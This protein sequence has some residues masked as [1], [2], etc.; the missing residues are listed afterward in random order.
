MRIDK[1]L[2]ECG[3]ASRTESAK[4]A[5]A[6]QIIVN[7]QVVKKADTHI[8]PES[9]KVT[10]MGQDVTYRKFTYVMLNKPDGYLSATE[11]GDG[12]TVMELLPAEFFKMGLFPCGR[13]DKDTF[14]LLIMTNDGETAHRLLSPKH[15]VPK[16]YRYI[17]A[18][19]LSVSSKTKL[20]AG[21]DIGGYVTKP[22]QINISESEASIEGEITITEGKFHQIKRMFE[23]VGNKIIYL[24]RISFGEI[25]LDT[26]LKR[27]EWR[28]LTD[29]EISLLT[30]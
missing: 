13:L 24:E 26:S 9:D 5:K 14:G 15:H 30:K 8:N 3:L 29:A 2:S 28:Y 1:F 11:D 23:A 7:G 12:A 6:G 22:S 10:F 27:G 4:A 18:N 25:P 17:S 19:P 21:V 20:E 16:T